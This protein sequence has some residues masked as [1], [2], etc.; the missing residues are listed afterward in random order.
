MRGR[1]SEAA[2]TRWR[3]QIADNF[4][5]VPESLIP[6]L[7]HVQR[8]AGYLPREAI[9][10]V[11][12]YLNVPE[13]RVFGVA[14][15]YALFH[16]EPQGRDR[17]T[18][19]R[20]TACHIHGSAALLETL[21]KE[22]GIKAGETTADQRLSLTTVGCLG[23]CALATPVV[24]NDRLYGRQT[25]TSVR[26]LMKELRMAKAGRVGKRTPRNRKKPGSTQRH[27]GGDR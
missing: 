27:R 19:C 3:R 20:G 21:E 6:A 16:L 12:R 9:T 17:I 1:T 18:V 15:F 22:L 24:V 4:D 14:S 8:K 25:N 26:L 2:V 13:S 5:A 23:P 10:A 7:Q 11:S